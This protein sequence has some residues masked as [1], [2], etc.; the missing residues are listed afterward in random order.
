MAKPIPTR[1][2]QAVLDVIGQFPRGAA[3]EQIEANLT[4]PPTRRTVQRWLTDLIAQDRLHKEGQGR[5]TRYLRGKTITAR[6]QVTARAQATVHAKILIPLSGEAKQIEAHVRQPL[7][8]RHP[9]GYNRAFL[10]NYQP[11]VS[12]YLPESIRAELLAH[13]QAAHTNEPAGTYAR[14]IANRLLIDLSWNSSRLEGNTY[15]LLETE[16][17]LSATA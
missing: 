12:F 6:V 13:G 9:V 3:I 7:Q 14:Q 2:H 15:S 11:N 17:L 16:R 10:E 5:A 4:T 8:T 1:E